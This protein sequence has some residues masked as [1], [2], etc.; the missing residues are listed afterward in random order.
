[1]IPQTFPSI[2]DANNRTKMV[3]YEVP[4]IVGLTRW[5][6]YIPVKSPPN[7]SDLSLANTFANAGFIL[8]NS[9]TSVT[10][11][12]AFKDYI[13]IYVDN[14]ATTPWTTDANGY[15]PLSDLGSLFSPL[16]LFASGEQGVWYDPSDITTMFQDSAGTTPVTAVEQ[17]V[18]LLLDKSK[19]LVLGSELVTNGTFNT[20]TAGP[21][22]TG[23]TTNPVG[24]STASVFSGKFIVATS[25]GTGFG[26]QGE[27]LTLSVGTTYRITATIRSVSGTTPSAFF[28]LGTVV[29]GFGVAKQL[30]N[31]T[32]VAQTY[33]G[34]FT[35]TQ[36]TNYLVV[37][38]D[39]SSTNAVTEFD[40]ISVQSL[41]G[42]HATQST[43]TKRPVL[44]ARYNLL[45]RTEEFD[46]VAWTAGGTTMTG[47]K[48]INTTTGVSAYRYIQIASG[49]S[50]NTSYTYSI[51]VL[52]TTGATTFPGLFLV[53]FTGGTTSS[54]GVTINTNTGVLTDRVGAAPTSKS[55]LDIGTHWRVTLEEVNNTNTIMRFDIYPAVNTDASGTWVS[56]ITGSVTVDRAQLI[57]TN[58][59]LSNAYQRVVTG[60]AG[61]STVS[62]TSDYDT[63]PTKFPPYLKFD[64]VD[65]AMKTTSVNFS[66]TDKMS[67][68]AGVRKITDTVGALCELTA[69]INSN[70]GSYYVITGTDSPISTNGYSSIARGTATA[71]VNQATFISNVNAPS[72]DVLAITHNIV[73]DLSTIRVDTVEGTNG[74]GDKGFGNFVNDRIYIGGR[75]EGS[76]YFNGNLY[77]LIIRGAASTATQIT[78]TETYVNSKTKAY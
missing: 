25:S 53:F 31:T 74:T 32:S 30:V 66:A 8:S 3:V 13:P 10:G 45:T 41:I 72:T 18:G 47:S 14:A 65:D 60:V 34:F 15:I 70:S 62:G 54:G 38:S 35:A 40:N 9:L 51:D 11:L 6:D 55:S 17:P 48:T 28:Y 36:A 19:G 1:M 71:A 24:L 26:R 43:G 69:N 22:V 75:G 21:T 59:L 29:G 39:S 64:G 20:D 5:I 50:P 73:G 37:G 44:S 4:S 67:I 58:S 12:Q 78:N 23:W 7:E 63:D 42:N 57:A 56:G 27:V 52:K 68:W 46:N 16:S 77:S 76:P 49:V 61:T 33:T 2:V